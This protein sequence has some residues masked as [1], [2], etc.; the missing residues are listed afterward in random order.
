MTLIEALARAGSTT[1]AAADEILIVR[2]AP[3][4]A[5]RADAARPGQ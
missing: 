2:P 5:D 4:K 1:P 3:G